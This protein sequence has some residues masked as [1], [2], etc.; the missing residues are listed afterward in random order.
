[1]TIRIV[2]PRSWDFSVLSGWSMTVSPEIYLLLI[3]FLL[4][5][6]ARHEAALTVQLNSLIRVAELE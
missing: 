3:V 6:W 1:M 4:S 2:Q 5:L